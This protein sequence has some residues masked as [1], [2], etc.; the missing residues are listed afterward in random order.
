MDIISQIRAHVA[1]A[2]AAAALAMHNARMPLLEAIAESGEV[3][4][5]VY[6]GYTPGFND[7]EP[8][9]HSFDWYVNLKEI[10][11]DETLNYGF[12]GLPEEISA[13]AEML[14]EQEYL[15]LEEISERLQLPI[16]K[17]S[18]EI[19]QGCTLLADLLDEE[20]NTNEWH[21][22]LFRDGKFVEFTGEY[23]CGY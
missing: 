1:E 11:Y 5:F 9:E 15:S 13:L 6:R 23:D 14:E 18:D 8:C 10:Q 19:Y 21:I 2:A 22:Y 17:P 12:E 3:G 20:H 7:G 4:I 16:N